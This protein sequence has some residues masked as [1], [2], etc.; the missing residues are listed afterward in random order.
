M[1][2]KK[3]IEDIKCFLGF[4]KNKQ[5]KK[6]EKLEE[7]HKK[8]KSKRNEL[9]QKLT[10]LKKDEKRKCLAEIKAIDVYLKKSNSK[11]KRLKNGN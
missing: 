4:N 9:G 10:N 3:I 2:V 1:K 8:L 5:A 6:I 7:L 11:L